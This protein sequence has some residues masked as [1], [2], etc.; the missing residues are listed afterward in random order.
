LLQFGKHTF[1]SDMELFTY[2][3]EHYFRRIPPVPT[4]IYL[5]SDAAADISNRVRIAEL[6]HFPSIINILAHDPDYLVRETARGNDFWVLVGQLQD[7]LG[8]G[9]QERKEFAEREVFRIILVLLMFE[10]D[11]EVLREALLNATVSTRMLVQY[12]RLL[13]KRGQ[14]KKDQQILAEARDILNEKKRRIF[15]A[16]EINRA[17]RR[18]PEVSAIEIIIEHLAEQDPVLFRAISNILRD[19]NPKLLTRFVEKATDSLFADD[20]LHK[21]L[22][23]RGLVSILQRREDIRK[24][25]FGDGADKKLSIRDVLLH[26]INEASKELVQECET[27][28]TEFNNILLIAHGHCDPDPVLR[29]LA[30]SIFALDDL[31]SLVADPSTPQY[32]FKHILRLLQEHPEEEIRRRATQVLQE[33]SRRMWN[34][35]NELEQTINAYFDLIFQSPGYRQVVDI[36]HTRKMIEIANQAVDR[37]A[38]RVEP[39]QKKRLQKSQPAFDEML[40]VIDQEILRFNRDVSLESLRDVNQ[41]HHMLLKILDLRDLGLD[42]LR[43]G[44]EKD[45]DAELLLKARTI[46]QSALGQ[47]LGRIKNLNEMMREKFIRLADSQPDGNDTYIE[48]KEASAFLESRHKSNVH[49]NLSITCRECSRRGC[50]SERFLEETEFLVHELLDNFVEE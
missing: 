43:P 41:I 28:L 15:H 36:Q 31:I 8:F 3:M 39:E 46:W 23:L 37:F 22:A 44:L 1:N 18:L 34:R 10:D 25:P 21:F 20:P 12:I 35:L 38:K 40:S 14:G 13:E 24:I 29:S 50:A 5:G 49:C 45:M 27:N 11:L 33:E 4:H 42:G 48:I 19:V 6:C 30:R 17:M 16:S 26:R 32:H 47:F 9:K 2:V 7:V